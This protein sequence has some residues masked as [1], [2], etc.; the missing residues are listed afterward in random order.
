LLV[1]RRQSDRPRHRHQQVPP[2]PADQPLDFAFVVALTRAAKPVGKDVMRLQLAEHPRPLADPVAQD[3]RHRQLGIVVQDRARNLAEE[4]NA[5]LC[6][7]Q[8]ASA[9]SA[10]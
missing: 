1:Q 9:V 3:A 7:S 5:A 8:N 10:G 4:L 2:D 6:P